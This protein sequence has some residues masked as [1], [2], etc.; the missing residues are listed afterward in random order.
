M[1]KYQIWLDRFR[2]SKVEA[3]ASEWEKQ[4]G[5]DTVRAWKNVRIAY[6]QAI[7]HRDAAVVLIFRQDGEIPLK[8]FRR[9]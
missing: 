4:Y 6:G 2:Q 5:A 9:Y 8:I 1:D 7:H 3:P